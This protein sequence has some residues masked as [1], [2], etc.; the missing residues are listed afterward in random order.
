MDPKR[1]TTESPGK[2]VQIASPQKDWAFLP[3][4]MPPEWEFPADLWPL[5]KDATAAMAK[6][7]GIGRYLPNQELLLRPLQ[8]REAI[9]SSSLEGTYVTP[10]QLLLYELDPREPRSPEDRA[11]EWREVHNYGRALQRGCEMLKKLPF[12]LRIVK[13]MHALL[14]QGVHGRTPVPGDFRNWQ[15]QIGSSG[16]FVPPPAEHVV[17][18][19]SN[20]EAYM[21]SNSEEYDPLVRCFLIHYQFEAIHPFVDGNGRVGRALL[22]L[23]IYKMLGHSMPWLYL[24]AFFERY[25]EEYIAKLFNISTRGDW[26]SWVEFCLRGALWQAND[27][28]RRF[29]KFI[30]LKKEFHQRAEGANASPRT[31]PIIESLFTDPIIN[32]PVIAEKHNVRY[33]TAKMDIDRLIDAGILKEI[34]ESYPKTFFAPD[35]M[36]AAYGSSEELENS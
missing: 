21:N 35:V 15:V 1:F 18:F 6:L 7:D 8:T 27:A 13:D 32:I 25:K 29:D 11:T 12:C 33:P 2:L 16:R 31:Y 26:T 9:T 17:Q 19:M 20:L 4:P 22:A 23:M 3:N 28:I 10:E 36:V 24:S 5:L 30:A 14:L 34:P